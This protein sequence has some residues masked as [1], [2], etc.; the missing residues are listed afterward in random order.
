MAAVASYAAFG[1]YATSRHFGPMDF[2]NQKQRGSI[3]S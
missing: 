3:V 1:G 2:A